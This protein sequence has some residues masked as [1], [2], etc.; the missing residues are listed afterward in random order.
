MGTRMAGAALAGLGALGGGVAVL[1]GQALHGGLA[2]EAPPTAGDNG[3]G[4]RALIRGVIEGQVTPEAAAEAVGPGVTAKDI[5]ALAKR[6][7][8]NEAAAA[9]PQLAAPAPMASVVP[10]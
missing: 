7:L 8:T 10:E 6:V 1:A 3:A 4:M 2:G 9:A 5:V